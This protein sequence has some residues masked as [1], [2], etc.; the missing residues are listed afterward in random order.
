MKQ[1]PLDLLVE[2]VPN[3]Y[4]LVVKAAKIARQI[5]E[6]ETVDES[7]NKL[8]GKPVTLALYEIA[9]SKDDDKDTEK[10]DKG[11]AS[12]AGETLNESEK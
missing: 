7:G 4:R 9:K 10:E 3:K 2:K 8:K 5:T 11:E 6:E 12:N 1:P